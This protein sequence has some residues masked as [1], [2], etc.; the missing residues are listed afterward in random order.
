MV[1]WSTKTA[2]PMMPASMVNVQILAKDPQWIAEPML[3]VKPL[4]IDQ[5][6]YV[7]KATKDPL[8]VKDASKLV[9]DRA[10][11]V[12]A[13]NGVTK[14]N[15]KIPAL[16]LVLAVKMLNVVFCTIKHCVLVPPDSLEIPEKSV[17]LMWMN[18]HRI[19]AVMKTVYSMIEMILNAGMNF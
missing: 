4:T 2:L 7:P 11:N 12:Q 6:A 8:L 13:T 17:F 15:V 9:A 18:V 16:I 14:A 5:S 3:F 19:L 10:K 1:A